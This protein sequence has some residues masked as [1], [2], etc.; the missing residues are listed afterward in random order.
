MPA[1]V[2]AVGPAQSF[3]HTVTIDAGSDAGLRP[4]MTVLND[5]GLVGRVTAVTSHTATVRLLVDPGS[6]VGGRIGD[7]MELGFVKGR[8]ELGDD[9]RLDLQLIDRGVVPRQG[10]EVVTWGARAARPTSPACRSARSPTSTSPLRDGTY[11]AGVEPYVDF[12][13]LDLVGV[14]VPSGEGVIE[15][16]GSVRIR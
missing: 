5:D 14:V 13:A 9:G 2:V 10:Q 3:S 8:G 16:D 1:R 15:V 12:T 6:E 4:D 11:R 7:N